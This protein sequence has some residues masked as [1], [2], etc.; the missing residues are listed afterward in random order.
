M[1]SLYWIF[2]A[3]YGRYQRWFATLAHV[4]KNLT[5]SLYYAALAALL[6]VLLSP[7]MVGTTIGEDVFLSD[8]TLSAVGTQS[9]HPGSPDRD[10]PKISGA[11]EGV[12]TCPEKLCITRWPT[13]F[14]TF[15]IAFTV[16]LARAPPRPDA[17]S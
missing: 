14:P 5:V 17:V 2:L 7:R 3:P 12:S 15:D 10:T 16:S 1:A 13:F 11:S 9:E 8:T 4:K 6:A